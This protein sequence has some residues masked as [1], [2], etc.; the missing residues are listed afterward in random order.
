MTYSLWEARDPYV[1]FTTEDG[2]LSM[3]NHPSSNY[4]SVN[5]WY[6]DVSLLTKTS[7]TSS[8]PS[9]IKFYSQLLLE[10]LF[11]WKFSLLLLILSSYMSPDL[12]LI[13]SFSLVVHVSKTPDYDLPLVFP[14][15]QPRFFHSSHSSLFI[16]PVYQPPEPP[17]PL[18]KPKGRP[19]NPSVPP[20]TRLLT[21]QN[22]KQIVLVR[23]NRQ[24]L[25][26]F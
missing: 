17:V 26:E 22:R 14:S 8:R 7:V 4:L 11:Y 24:F 9:P 15:P 12:L 23:P 3:E 2:S 5:V 1:L 25:L 13:R 21:V 16:L 10:R 19:L 6:Y 18:L 20:K